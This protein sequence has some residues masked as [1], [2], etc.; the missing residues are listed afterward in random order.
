LPASATE[1][2]M[3]ETVRKFLD[4]HPEKMQVAA[5][6]LVREALA[7]AYPCP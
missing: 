5:Q 3:V 7:A 6:D 4:A 2:V 1:P